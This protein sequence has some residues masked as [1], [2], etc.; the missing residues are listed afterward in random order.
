MR[1]LV[2]AALAFS[3]FALLFNLNS[4]IAGS[5]NQESAAS[6]GGKTFPASVS[7]E[8]YRGYFWTFRKLPSSKTILR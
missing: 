8:R 6:D 1:A 3:V 5:D 7:G 4:A 2:P